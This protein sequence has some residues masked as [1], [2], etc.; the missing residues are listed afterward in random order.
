[1]RESLNQLS[2]LMDSRIESWLQELTRE[3]AI[4]FQGSLGAFSH[5][6]VH[7]PSKDKLRLANEMRIQL[8][9][10]ALGS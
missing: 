5:V 4:F 3:G 6:F 10:P 8:L 1:M 7:W 2:G 9:D